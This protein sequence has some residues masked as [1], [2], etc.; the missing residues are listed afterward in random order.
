MD[1]QVTNTVITILD[2][3]Q[4][5][6]DHP[7]RHLW[8]DIAGGL[9][10]YVYEGDR[11]L[12]ATIAAAAAVDAFR[13][14]PEGALVGL[15][16]ASAFDVRATLGMMHKYAFTFAA[17]CS[18]DGNLVRVRIALR[19]ATDALRLYLNAAGAWQAAAATM[20]FGVGTV[21]RKFGVAIPEI[22]Y[23][24]AAGNNIENMVWQVSNGTAAA[25]VIDLDDLAITDLYNSYAAP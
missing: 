2:R 23:V 18:V 16:A 14:W 13:I 6:E 24:D 5:A 7:A 9:N 8:A 4:E 22:P 10:K 1:A 21:W 20:N 11:A 12:R 19:D 17:R 25:Q 15:T 3:T